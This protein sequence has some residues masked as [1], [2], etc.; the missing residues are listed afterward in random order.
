MIMR[1][2]A[3]SVSAVVTLAAV[4]SL[5]LL[6]LP[7][8]GAVASTATWGTYGPVTFGRMAFGPDGTLYTTDCGNARIYRI[9]TTGRVSV[10]AG[11]GAG[12]F[13]NGYSGDGGPALDAHFGCPAGLAFDAAGN[14]YVADHLNDAVRKID[15]SGTV[16]TIAGVGPP[17]KSWFKGPTVPGPGAH[18]GDGGPATTA[19]LDH[20]TWIEFD[21]RGNLYIDDRDEDA[22][23]MVDANGIIS[24]VAGVGVRGYAGDGGPA[25]DARLNRPL[26]VAFDPTGRMFIADEGNARLRAVSAGGV[27]TT[28]GGTGSL[29][30]AGDGGPATAAQVQNPNSLAFAPDG[31]LYMTEGECHRVRKIM[32][33]G[34]IRAAIGSGT[35]GCSY[36]NGASP[37]AIQLSDPEEIRVG[38][39]GD[40]Y[41]SDATCGVILSVSSGKVHVVASAPQTD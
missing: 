9:S 24:T 19:T 38:P 7:S 18:N 23:R 39:H 28:A 15:T 41:V 33:D 14:L 25:V 2:H 4:M 11:A 6:V 20:P 36:W 5:T 22:I 10:F 27:I 1:S 29:G 34:T 40:L 12:G 32:P 30:C 3:R 31:A 26:D 35:D 16:S 8:S 37:L 13:D 17:A 21:A